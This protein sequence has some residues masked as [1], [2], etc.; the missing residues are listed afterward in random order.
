MAMKRPLGQV[1]DAILTISYD[2]VAWLIGRLSPQALT[3]PDL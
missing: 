3:N 2:R 1:I